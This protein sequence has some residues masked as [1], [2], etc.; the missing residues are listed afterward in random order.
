MV[1]RGAAKVTF[2]QGFTV[3]QEKLKLFNSFDP[4]R[5]SWSTRKYPLMFEPRAPK[6][7]RS[8]KSTPSKP[9][10]A[11]VC[12][13]RVLS[14]CD[15]FPSA[16]SWNWFD[17]SKKTDRSRR[18][19]R[20]QAHAWQDVCGPTA[21]VSFWHGNA[22]DIQAIAAPMSESKL[23]HCLHAPGEGACRVAAIWPTITQEVHCSEGW[24]L[25]AMGVCYNESLAWRCP[26]NW[27]PLP[28]APFCSPRNVQWESIPRLDCYRSRFVDLSHTFCQLGEC[29]W[30]GLLRHYLQFG[31]AERRAAHCDVKGLAMPPPGQLLAITPRAH[32]LVSCHAMASTATLE[33]GW[34]LDVRCYL[35]RYEHVRQRFCAPGQSVRRCT[36]SWTTDEFCAVVKQFAK[37]GQDQGLRFTCDRTSTTPLSMPTL[38]PGE[39]RTLKVIVPGHG[40]PQRTPLLLHSIDTLKRNAPTNV[41]FSCTIFVYNATL[42][43]YPTTEE[44]SH[45]HRCDIVVRA[46]LWTDF[47]L[48]E[49]GNSDYILV[50]MDDVSPFNIGLGAMLQTM[51]QHGIDELSPSILPAW[52]WKN[53]VQGSSTLLRRVR[54]ADTLLAVFKRRAFEC[55]KS[56]IDLRENH[57]GWGYDVAFSTSCNVSV[58][59][60]DQHLALH[61]TGIGGSKLKER[62]YNETE[63]FHQMWSY[64]RR[65]MGWT[66]DSHDQ[67]MQILI[68][69]NDAAPTSVVTA[70]R[71]ALLDPAYLLE[72]EHRGGWRAVMHH[73]IRRDV[74]SVNNRGGQLML[75]DCAEKWFV[76]G[77]QRPPWEEGVREPWV[78][79]IHSTPNLPPTYPREETLQGL[80]GTP[81]FIASVP[82]CRLIIVFAE[83]LA[84]EL[85]LL[86]P[87]VSVKVMWHPFGMDA[88]DPYQLFSMASFEERRGK[89]EM[90]FLGQQY[91][92]LST[93]SRLQVPYRKVW[94][95]GSSKDN[96]N[97][98]LI[99]HS[100]D[101]MAASPNLDSFRIAYM[102][103]HNAYDWMLLHNIV[104]VD[105]WDAAANN[106]VVE[107]IGMTN[108]I[109][110]N[111]HPAIVE[112]LG[113]GYPLYFNDVGSLQALLN[114]EH[115]LLQ[116]TRLAH[117]YLVALPKSHFSLDHFASQLNQTVFALP[118]SPS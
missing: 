97:T 20:V 117:E 45:P 31:R 2:A 67:G 1:Q 33:V 81:A 84:R 85:R 64:L 110:I 5:W 92:R 102:R 38:Q 60:S 100:R 51:E 52:N 56:K 93:L 16:E 98:F 78:G 39:V 27:T 96:N 12:L 30:T 8:L 101:E 70:P 42:V 90:V 41:H 66:F 15:S 4:F 108:P 28:L 9:S 18:A 37:L 94:L 109:H 89:W 68:A 72:V 88:G 104:V 76:W 87:S 55:W 99:K 82:W 116:R 118:F 7:P 105:V 103:D 50:M 35:Q 49:S 44:F 40:A 80:L 114:D 74:L 19:C 23:K 62:L 26:M 47:M 71:L 107:A 48:M 11:S 86:L 111:K 10:E 32:S 63:T 17:D 83:Y 13:I 36:A 115:T 34:M 43:V 24:T 95:P 21:L 25:S 29:D 22:S 58:A 113:S 73:A 61:A 106:A 79:M 59:V 46:G 57:Y 54:M 14:T 3:C 69:H 6:V 77:G 65:H 53:M 112:Y 91:R 75:I